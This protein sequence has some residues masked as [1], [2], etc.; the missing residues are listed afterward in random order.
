MVSNNKKIRNATVVKSNKITFKSMLEKM[1]YNTLLEQ[2]FNP[3]YEPKQITLWNGFTPI[4]PYYDEE[5]KNH[6]LKRREQGDKT[7]RKLVQKNSKIIGIRYTCDFYIKYGD[8]ISL[9]PNKTLKQI[10][11]SNILPYISYSKI[12]SYIV[13][14]NR[15]IFIYHNQLYNNNNDFKNIKI[16]D[17]YDYLNE[18]YQKG[19]GEV[20][21][22]NY[23]NDPFNIPNNPDEEYYEEVNYTICYCVIFD[24]CPQRM[25]GH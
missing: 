1:C 25:F 21:N 9:F 20:I 6:L 18:L 4:T 7:P 16:K 15:N 19:N 10:I 2:G 8:L 23:E 12:D 11:N 13:K 24:D 5:S 17:I 3:Q 22:Y 14:D